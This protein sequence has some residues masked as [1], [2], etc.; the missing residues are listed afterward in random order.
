MLKLFQRAA[1]YSEFIKAGTFGI[2]QLLSE[3]FDFFHF[4]I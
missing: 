4:F 2:G 1:E 3:P